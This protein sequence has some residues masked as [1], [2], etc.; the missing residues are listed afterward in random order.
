MRKSLQG[1]YQVMSQNPIMRVFT[2][3][4]FVCWFQPAVNWNILVNL[5]H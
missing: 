5:S 2:A 3:S 1:L 4:G